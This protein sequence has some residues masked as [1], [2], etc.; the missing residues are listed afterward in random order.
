LE[1]FED[2]EYLNGIYDFNPNIQVEWI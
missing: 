2:L 1:T